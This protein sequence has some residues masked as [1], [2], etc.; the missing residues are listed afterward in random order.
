MPDAQYQ[1]LVQTVQR[2][3]KEQIRLER[4][5][6]DTKTRVS[7]LERHVALG[8]LTGG[9][10]GG[11]APPD[12]KGGGG[13]R[14]GEGAESD[15]REAKER[16]APDRR[17]SRE[18]PDRR[19]SKDLPRD[20]LG[21]RSDRAEE[22]AREGTG[23][24]VLSQEERDKITQRVGDNRVVVHLREAIVREYFFL[25]GAWWSKKNAPQSEPSRLSVGSEK[26]LTGEH[27]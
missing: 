9:R 5:L 12:F 26:A 3:E 22:G 14:P 4:E 23:S 20:T 7:D 15:Y 25:R 6:T 17:C 16:P 18:R 27:S 1:Y 24:A 11:A 8:G 10:G 13:R 19:E 2:L 21:A